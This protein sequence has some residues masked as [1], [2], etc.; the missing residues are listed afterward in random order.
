MYTQK[1]RYYSSKSIKGAD[2]KIYDS[3]FEG[4][5][6]D[7]LYYRK[8]AKDIKD[9]QTQVPL[10]LIVNGYKIGKYIADFII[11]HND[12]SKEI[13]ETKGFSTDVFKLKWKL[14]EALYSDKY[15]L[16]LLMQKGE[17]NFRK[18]KKIREPI[19]Y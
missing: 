2:G 18:P 8:L 7:E 15:T 16:T 6:G 12:G 11:T 17:R 9:Y 5:Y 13:V 14:V 3:K 10:D 4:G 19:I 1:N